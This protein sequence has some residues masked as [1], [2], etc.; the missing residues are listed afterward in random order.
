M[1]T[2]R[3]DYIWTILKAFSL[4]VLVWTVGMLAWVIGII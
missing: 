3:F 2:G 4:F 1:H